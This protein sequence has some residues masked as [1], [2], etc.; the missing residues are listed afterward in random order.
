MSQIEVTEELLNKQIKEARSEK[1]KNEK[2][3]KKLGSTI[4]LAIVIILI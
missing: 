4:G 1:E 2:L 3:Y